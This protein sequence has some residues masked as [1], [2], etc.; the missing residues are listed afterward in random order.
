[1]TSTQLSPASLLLFRLVPSKSIINSSS[2]QPTTYQ[3]S[4]WRSLAH[5]RF[6][7]SLAARSATRHSPYTQSAFPLFIYLNLSGPLTLKTY[8]ELGF[9]KHSSFSPYHCGICWSNGHTFTSSS[10]DSTEPPNCACLPACLPTCRE[11]LSADSWRLSLTI[12]P[13]YSH[14]SQDTRPLCLAF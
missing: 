3:L 4:H 5:S 9:I 12:T 13:S 6:R 2:H 7:L 10:S 11:S 1:M 8:E 14:R